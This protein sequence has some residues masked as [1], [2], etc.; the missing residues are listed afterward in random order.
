MRR[1]RST[2]PGFL[3]AE[4]VIISLGVLVALGADRWVRGLDEKT[5]TDTYLVNLQS[6]LRQDSLRFSVAESQAHKNVLNAG[7]L[8]SLL[9]EG[10]GPTTD[11]K[12]VL[13][14]LYLLS[15]WVPRGFRTVTWTD[16]LAT[17]NLRLLDNDLRRELSVYYGMQ[18]DRI[19][20]DDNQ[21]P[22]R[23]YKSVASHLLKPEQEMM[24]MYIRWGG[25][26]PDTV[27]SAWEAND[28]PDPGI[29]VSTA[30]TLSDDEFA[31]LI[32][33][34]EATPG[35]EAMLGDMLW[36]SIWHKETYGIFGS[37]A[38]H[39]LADPRVAGAAP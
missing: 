27:S 16:L 23:R 17:G 9:R 32:D 13:V 3:V 35:L 37:Y 10:P 21:E 38:A 34:L 7:L 31:A 36:A 26:D 15:D 33:R 12:E 2:S 6:D 18:P 24:A 11:R 4:F 28:L 8:L 20:S 22:F 14:A 25:A 39:H 29:E 30:T 1:I 5:L 19:E